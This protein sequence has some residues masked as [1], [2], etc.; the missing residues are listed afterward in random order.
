MIDE[1]ALR[2]MSAGERAE[3]HRLLVSIDA[4][5]PTLGSNSASVMVPPES[6]CLQ[7][8]ADHAPNGPPGREPDTADGRFVAILTRTWRPPLFANFTTL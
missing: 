2:A 5:L 4:D 8:S 7:D 6:N 3:L 1:G